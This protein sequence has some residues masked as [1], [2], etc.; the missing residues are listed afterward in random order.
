MEIVP[1]NVR[2][3]TGLGKSESRRMRTRG[4]VPGI[5][6]GPKL[7]Q[8]VPIELDSREFAKN[9]DVLEGSHLIQ[10]QSDAGE[11]AQKMVLL[12]EVQRHPVT[13]R[14]LHTDFYEV[15]LT[16]KLEVE[17][18]LH[19][20]GK[21]VGALEGGILQPIVREVTVRCLPTEIPN[22][23]EVDVTPLDIHDALHIEDLK[24]PEGVEPVF[25]DNFTVVTVQPP[26]VEEVPVAAAEAAPVEGAAAPAAEGSAKAEGGKSAAEGKK[27]E[28]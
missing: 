26:T 13:G 27:G 25:D 21:P 5:F 6:Y 16:Q 24:F 23:I 22:Y 28:S 18:S 17:V 8:A 1:L 4:A 11:L 20:T 14:V 3:R 12:R 19:F 15:D 2:K 9:I 7:E 10:L